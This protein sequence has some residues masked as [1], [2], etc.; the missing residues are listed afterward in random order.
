MVKNMLL[1]DSSGCNVGREDNI[2]LYAKKF[3]QDWELFT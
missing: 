2:A 3:C 1:V